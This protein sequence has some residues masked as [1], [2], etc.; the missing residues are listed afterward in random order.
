MNQ[1]LRI[2]DMIIRSHT[3]QSLFF[4][5]L[6]ILGPSSIL[7]TRPYNLLCTMIRITIS[8]WWPATVLGTALQPKFISGL[9][10]LKA[11]CMHALGDLYFDLHDSV[12]NIFLA[13]SVYSNSSLW[14]FRWERCIKYQGKSS[15]NTQNL[16]PSFTAWICV[17]PRG[18]QAR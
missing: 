5:N 7:Q 2:W 6:L 17:Y 9:V 4:H 18:N 16:L 14:T 1:I 13:L 8:V 11:T 12:I 3:T 10:S 15:R